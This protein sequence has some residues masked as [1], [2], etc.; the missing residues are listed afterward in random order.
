MRCVP[1]NMTIL[2]FLKTEA[3]V[4]LRAIYV[5]TRYIRKTPSREMRIVIWFYYIFSGTCISAMTLTDLLMSSQV[6]DLVY[7]PITAPCAGL[8]YWGVK[9]IF[10]YFTTVLLLTC[11]IIVGWLIYGF[12]RKQLDSLGWLLSRTT[13]RRHLPAASGVWLMRVQLFRACKVKS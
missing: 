7:I 13:L 4:S 8:G 12:D 1:K 5:R 10:Y 11:L 3:K 2:T 6:P 9:V